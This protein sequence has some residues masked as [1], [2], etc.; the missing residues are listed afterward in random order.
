MFFGDCSKQ[1]ATIQEL[2]NENKALREQIQS[3]LRYS[4]T[5][6]PVDYAITE[7]VQEAGY[8]RLRIEYLSNE[9]DVIPA[10]LLIPDGEAVCPAVPNFRSIAT[11]VPQSLSKPPLAVHILLSLNQISSYA[12]IS[13]VAKT[14]AMLMYLLSLPECEINTT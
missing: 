11:Y 4:K 13:C 8:S 3:F 12:S 2:Q 5:N 10:Y 9:G 1:D 7:T 14:I 6:R